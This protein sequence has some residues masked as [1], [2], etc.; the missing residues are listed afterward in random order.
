MAKGK[1]KAGA[2]EASLPD[3]HSLTIDTS[4]G[5]LGVT[6]SNTSFGTGVLI[7]DLHPSDLIASAGLQV[8]DVILTVQ[9]KA[10]DTH[11]DAFAALD[12]AGASLR[13]EYWTAVEADAAAAIKGP[14]SKSSSWSLWLVVAVAV[15]AMAATIGGVYYTTIHN[16]AELKESPAAKTAR[17]VGPKSPTPAAPS[18]PSVLIDYL[19]SPTFDAEHFA[20]LL[21]PL[22][23]GELIS[24]IQQKFTGQWK[25]K[26]T[27]QHTAEVLKDQLINYAE[28]SRKQQ[29]EFHASHSSEERT[30]RQKRQLKLKS[31]DELKGM[32][33]AV[34]VAY[35]P[36]ATLKG[37]RE[38][39]LEEKVLS[40]WEELPEATRLAANRKHTAATVGAAVAAEKA[41]KKAKELAE[42]MDPEMKASMNKK[43]KQP[44]EIEWD[45]TDE[46]EA[47]ERLS[48]LDKFASMDPAQLEQTMQMVREDKSVLSMMESEERTQKIMAEATASG[49]KLTL[50][51]MKRMGAGVMHFDKTKSLDDIALD[52]SGVF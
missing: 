46:D 6:L 52:G 40:K 29:A 15:V 21:E 31:A 19:D 51:D 26:I 39:A 10:V 7:S 36:D 49:Q 27:E 9:G 32:M 16:A 13:L 34:G 33:D 24:Q 50:G 38:R 47:L 8:G 30:K 23:R 5:H 42:D 37:L 17:P 35:A 4:S 25:W 2:D 48:K 45:S 18:R 43:R 44:W 14:A 28:T 3:T 11:A 12:R 22:S 1:S 41:R 20:D